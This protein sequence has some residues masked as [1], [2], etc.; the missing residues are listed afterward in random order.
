MHIKF[1][2]HGRGS[3]K[4]AIDYLL[5]DRDHQGKE[6][7]SVTV[8]RETR[9]W[10]LKWWTHYPFKIDIPAGLSPQAKTIDET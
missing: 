2:P 9:S 6:R 10:L 8:L 7:E 1:L 5:S 3:G 4:A